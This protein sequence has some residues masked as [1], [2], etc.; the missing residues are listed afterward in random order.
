MPE[1]LGWLDPAH[2]RT[3][4]RSDAA[5]FCRRRIGADVK[6][7]MNEVSLRLCYLGDMDVPCWDCL[8]SIHTHNGRFQGGKDLNVPCSDH[9]E[10]NLTPGSALPIVKF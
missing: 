4:N 3:R 10:V 2:G 6:V 9:I 8:S 1:F 7:V 5:E